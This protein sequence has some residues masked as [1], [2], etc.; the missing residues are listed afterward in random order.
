[1]NKFWLITIL[2]ILIILLIFSIICLV[3]VNI[4]EYILKTETKVT[5]NIPIEKIP[6][7]MICLER[8][9]KTRC[10]PS[11]EEFKK[12]FPRLERN[13]AIDAK[14]LDIDK[15]ELVHPIT[16]THI[17]LKLSSDH[18]YINSKGAVGCF[19]SHVE[20]WKK[21]I[22]HNEPIIVVEDDHYQLA[23]WQLKELR[24][25]YQTI[26]ENTHFAS[27]LYINALTSLSKCK[28]EWCDMKPRSFRGTQLY[29]ISP[30]A[31]K[32]LL[33]YAFPI[34]V[35]VDAYISYILSQNK[36]LN[37]YVWGRNIW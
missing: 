3:K 27:I 21:C 24:R 5:N 25:A 4:R 12:L 22:E 26:P 32:I 23:D 34:T 20:L 9:R 17:N 29:Y 36:D 6:V 15:S 7:Y 1:M 33:H 14:E 28:D 16:K 11:F 31:A 30:K 18:D 2:I 8:T 37:N 13:V 19:L 35:Q 10:D